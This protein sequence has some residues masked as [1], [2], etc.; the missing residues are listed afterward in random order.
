LQ[1]LNRNIIISVL[2]GM[3]HGFLNLDFPTILPQAN[4]AILY[5]AQ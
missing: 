1:R 3:P 5:A 2:Q 4:K